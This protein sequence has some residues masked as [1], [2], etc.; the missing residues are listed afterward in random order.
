[1]ATR[2]KKFP[3]I[4]PR[5]ACFR[6]RVGKSRIRG[7]GVF[8]AEPIPARRKVIEYTGERINRRE[9][10]RR[11]QGPNWQYV[12]LLN[13]RWAIDARFSGGGAELVNHGC[14]PNLFSTR[15]SGHVILVSRRRIRPG[16]ELT[17]DY[18]YSPAAPVVPC[19]C[20]SPQC[21]GTINL[22][23]AR[24]LSRAFLRA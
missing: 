6:L 13:R 4:D 5:Y 2:R 3:R 19:H 20:G 11:L 24:P 18:H 17:Y 21:R 15:R 8:A 7:L 10:I 23:T 1:M 14:D 22:K 9:T 12:F 16:E